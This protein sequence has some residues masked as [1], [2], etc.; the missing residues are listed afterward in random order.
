M[1]SEISTALTLLLVGMITVFVVLFL[2]YFAGNLLISF[3]NK[4]IP[5][6]ELVSPK[7][8]VDPRKLAVITA[9]VDQITGGQGNITEIKKINK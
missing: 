6:A 9:V 1:S 2:V 5:E 8:Q 7:E 4:Y 3:V